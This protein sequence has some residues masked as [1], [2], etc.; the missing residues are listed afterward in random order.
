MFSDSKLHHVGQPGQGLNAG[1]PILLLDLR[2]QRFVFQVLVLIQPLLQLDDLQWISRSHQHLAEHRI[3]IERD[4]RNQR[5]QLIGRKRDDV[6]FSGRRRLL[7]LTDGNSHAA[8]TKSR[9]AP[10]CSNISKC[11]KK[12]LRPEV[13]RVHIASSHD[14][15]NL[16]RSNRRCPDFRCGSF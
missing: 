8:Q 6:L 2:G 9:D 5:V 12:L 15:T 1:V 14:A 13:V 10:A 7:C 3:G 11:V 4:G 16:P